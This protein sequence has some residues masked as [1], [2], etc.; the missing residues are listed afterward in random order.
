MSHWFRPAFA[1]AILFCIDQG[2]VGVMKP[3]MRRDG[4][5]CVDGGRVCNPKLAQLLGDFR[6]RRKIFLHFR[7][8][9]PGLIPLLDRVGDDRDLLQSV[10]IE[11]LGNARACGSVGQLLIGDPPDDFVT[12]RTVGG[13]RVNRGGGEKKK[14]KKTVSHRNAAQT[15]TCLAR[16]GERRIGRAAPRPV[17]SGLRP[18]GLRL[19][20]RYRLLPMPAAA[21]AS[22]FPLGPPPVPRRAWPRSTA[23]R[24]AG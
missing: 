5:I 2:D 20:S 21:A 12:I 6:A 23:S 11:E 15:M 8:F 14:T 24:P 3:M 19:P 4:G 10:A 17:S 22:A 7:I 16:S 13:C 9:D 1:V 18:T